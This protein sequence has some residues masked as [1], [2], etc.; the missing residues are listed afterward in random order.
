M[1][2][3]NNDIRTVLWFAVFPAVLA[4]VVLVVGVKEP[5]HSQAK[6][7]APLHA[8]EIGQLPSAYWLV[9]IAGTVLT[10]ARFSEA[11]LVIRAR[12]VGLA[13]AWAPAVIGVMSLVYAASAFRQAS[14][15]TKSARALCCFLASSLSS[16]QTC[17]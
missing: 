12:D 3:F 4:V 9:I 5:A 16:R 6:L 1:Y 2:L 10:L 14:S 17:F 11:F 8:K 7:R 13:L 15:R